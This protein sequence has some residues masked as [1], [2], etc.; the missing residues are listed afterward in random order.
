MAFY[1]LFL[2]KESA[3]SIPGLFQQKC[4]SCFHCNFGDSTEMPPAEGS[5]SLILLGDCGMCV[6]PQL[7]PLKAKELQHLTVLP[8]IAL[9]IE[10]TPEEVPSAL[11]VNST[12]ESHWNLVRT[13]TLSG[14]IRQNKKRLIWTFFC[15]SAAS[16]M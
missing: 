4:T 12:E 14:T 13:M 2:K 6:T 5:F 11:P 1:C 7:P 10:V 3:K 15:L 8:R 9:A 16:C